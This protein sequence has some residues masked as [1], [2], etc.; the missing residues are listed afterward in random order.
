M[1]L[2]ESKL[3]TTLSEADLTPR[4]RVYPSPVNWRDQVLYFLL[5]DRFS[6]GQEDSRPLFDPSNPEQFLASDLSA[7]RA[8]GKVFQ[9]GTLK[10]IAT[11]LDY[12]QELGVT[13]L[14]IGPIWRQRPDLQTYHGYGIQNFLDVDPRFGTR[15]DLR[16]LVDAAHDRG[17]YVLLDIIY[18][19]TGNNWFY[20]NGGIPHDT[21]PYRYSP[22]HPFGGWRSGTG[23]PIPHPATIDDGA[24]PEEFQNLDWYNRAGQIG[25]WDPEPWEDPLHP[26][27]EFRRGDFYDLKDLNV[28]RD[29]ALSAVIKA[30]QY[31]IAL[32]DCDGF[33][34]DT[35]K[36][37]S[38]DGSR[39]FCGA[40]HEYAEMIGKENFWLLGEVT[41]GGELTRSYLDIFGRNIDAAL[42]IG[43]PAH[44]L[45]GM[46][47]GQ[48]DARA[49]FSQFAG[50]NILGS[51]RETGR[52]HVSILD[53]HDMVGRQGKHRFSAANDIPARYEQVAHAVGSQ[54]A[55]LGVPCIYYGTEQAFDGT[56]SRGDHHNDPH[57]E[58]RYI[59]E[60]MFG[61]SFGAFATQGC[62]F[63]NTEHPAYTRI[64]AIARLRNNPDLV[65][66]ALRRGRQYQREV[67]FLGHPF[68]YPAPGEVIAWSRLLHQQEVLVALNSHG[69]ENR[70]AEVTVDA[71]LH[72]PGSTMRVI[73][74]GEW[75]A[76]E[77]NLV[78][79]DQQIHVENLPVSDI[80]GRAAVRI[81]LPPAGMA[82]MA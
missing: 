77:L 39:N 68:H 25:K 30:F 43:E 69:T 33:R 37:I 73:Y 18:N 67:A 32:S 29:D 31:W 70:G 15:Q 62:H 11:R 24:W 17:M 36:H 8:C 45:A 60:T 14:W 28:D 64:A 80:A 6:D 16:D 42:D 21:L 41:G 50:H 3:P 4:G 23:T 35:V 76:G 26:D 20:E 58:D 61:G 82:I 72:P 12:L 34:I 38:F 57:F 52:Y 9:G 55:C 10:G 74:R 66:L 48:V 7:W 47:K 19:H 1:T 44:L 5:P 2:V 51:H 40:I 54:L 81:D 13:A 65:G 59:R 78:G 27:N 53:D 46:V 79:T 63:F 22:P 75:S 49:F 71:N 56:E